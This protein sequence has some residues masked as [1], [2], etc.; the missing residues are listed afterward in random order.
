MPQIPWRERLVS[1]KKDRKENCWISPEGDW[2]NVP[3]ADHQV[4]AMRVVQE[5]YPTD[6]TEYWKSIKEFGTTLIKY[7]WVYVESTIWTGTIIMGTMNTTQHKVLKQYWG[8]TPLFRGWTI[9]ALYA[10]DLKGKE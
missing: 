4:F 2:Y 10:E 3:Y 6:Y 8:N 7:G 1:K 9:D 5:L